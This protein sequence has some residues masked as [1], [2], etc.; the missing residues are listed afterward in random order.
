MATKKSAPAQEPIE[1]LTVGDY[2]EADLAKFGFN[3]V[4]PMKGLDA[5]YNAGQEGFEE[6]QTKLGLYKGTKLCIST[7]AKKPNWKAVEGQPG[8]VS[9]KLH[10][11]QAAKPDGELLP[12]TF[13]IWSAGVLTSMLERIRPNQVIAVTYLGVAEEAY[14]EGQTAPHLFRLRGNNLDMTMAD[15]NE[16]QGSDEST[17]APQQ[18]HLGRLPNGSAVLD[19]RAAV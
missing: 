6:G 2:N 3:E 1:D 5:I 4:D 12:K 14:K 16:L 13:G 11:F 7:K 15:L 18:S 19:S 17:D 9:R 10:V 8:K